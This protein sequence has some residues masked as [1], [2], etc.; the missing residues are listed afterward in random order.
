MGHIGDQFRLQ[1]LIFQ[2]IA[3]GD[4]R[5]IGDGIDIRSQFIHFST[6]SVG[7]RLHRNFPVEI[8]VSDLCCTGLHRR[9]LSH[10]PRY[11]NHDE[12]N[13]H[14][15][16]DPGC[17]KNCTA[18]QHNHHLRHDA[19]VFPERLHQ[20]ADETL[21]APIHPEPDAAQQ[22][23]FPELAGL[24]F[25]YQRQEEEYCQENGSCHPRYTEIDY[26]LIAHSK[27]VIIGNPLYENEGPVRKPGHLHQRNTKCHGSHRKPAYTGNVNL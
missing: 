19:A 15:K 9:K 25:L 7:I 18:D 2:F 13:H 10:K 26:D 4:F 12:H 27:P 5:C 11:E 20:P 23:L 24:Q 21:H 1:P 16:P 3:D 6:H 17:R 22:R 14:Q 8:S